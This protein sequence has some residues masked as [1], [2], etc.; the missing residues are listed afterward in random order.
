MELKTEDQLVPVQQTPV[1]QQEVKK[2]GRPRKLPKPVWLKKN[3][4]NLITHLF[5]SLILTL[6]ANSIL[7][8]D[9]ET[10]PSGE[11]SDDIIKASPGLKGIHKVPISQ[12]INKSKVLL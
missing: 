4:L 2:R 6:I 8:E 9:S 11:E 10:Q 1:Q 3:W 12:S 5:T 7:Q